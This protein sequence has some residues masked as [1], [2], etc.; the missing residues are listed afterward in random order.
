MK[1]NRRKVKKEIISVALSEEQ[2]DGLIALDL[3]ATISSKIRSLIDRAVY[4]RA[5]KGKE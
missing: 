3:G 4:G 2:Y 5:Y 1:T